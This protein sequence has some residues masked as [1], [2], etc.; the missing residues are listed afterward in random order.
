MLL[1]FASCSNLNKK[2]T[3]HTAMSSRLLSN[4]LRCRCLQTNTCLKSEIKT[5]ER[6]MKYVQK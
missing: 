1:R 3:K 2:A 5:L 6:S 4:Q